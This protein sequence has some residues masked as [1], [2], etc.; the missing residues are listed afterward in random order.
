MDHSLVLPWAGCVFSSSSESRWNPVPPEASLAR[1]S[2]GKCAHSR[3]QSQAGFALGMLAS[4][5]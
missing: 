2:C 1:M 5:V 3:V 4:N